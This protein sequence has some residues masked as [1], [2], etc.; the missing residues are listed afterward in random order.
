MELGSKGLENVD[1]SLIDVRPPTRHGES[2]HEPIAIE[3]LSGAVKE[4]LP[5]VDIRLT[6][7]QFHDNGQIPNDALQSRVVGLSIGVGDWPTAQN[8]LD[9]A[10]RNGTGDQVLVA[11]GSYATYMPERL[12][13]EVPHLVCIQ[14]EGEEGLVKLLQIVMANRGKTREQ[15]TRLFVSNEVPGLAVRNDDVLVQIPQQTTD[16]SRAPLPDR[17]LLPETLSRGGVSLIEMGRGCQHNACSFCCIPGK[18]NGEKWRPKPIEN[19]IQDLRDLSNAGITRVDLAD[20]D[21][22]GNDLDRAIKLCERIL[23]EKRQGSLNPVLTFSFV[24]LR[25]K[26]LISNDLMK[27]EKIMKLLGLMKQAGFHEVFLGLESGACA[28]LKRMRKGS[29][30]KINAQAVA[31]LNEANMPFDFGFIFFDKESS[32]G[33]LKESIRFLRETGLDHRHPRVIKKMRIQPGTVAGRNFLGYPGED[34][35]INMDLLAYE[36]DFDDPQ[37]VEVHNRFLEWEDQNKVSTDSFC[38]AIGYCD[39]VLRKE[40]EAILGEIRST[41]LRVLE[42]IIDATEN[43]TA[44][45][46]VQFHEEYSQLID[47]GNSILLENN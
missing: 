3:V 12:I 13:E 11:G 21:F 17:V 28:A 29:S 39:D 15:L 44:I 19:I 8:V 33:D 14:G 4:A 47:A 38:R 40:L 10:V 36:Y 30:P 26:S 34:K 43:C 31:V 41:D 37:V 32:L 9:Q 2:L 24:D 6:S 35:P 45:N 18:H 7:N 42:H 1:L 27:Q 46:L 23:E 5:E 25:A 20:E 16:L 22:I